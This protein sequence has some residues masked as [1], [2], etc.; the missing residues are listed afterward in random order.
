V[1]DKGRP[2]APLESP[3]EGSTE[4]VPQSSDN[5]TTA[6]D[7]AY[8]EW[9]VQREADSIVLLELL[10]IEALRLLSTEQLHAIKWIGLLDE[11]W[12]RL[13]LELEQRGEVA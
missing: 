9:A 12:S 4:S 3:A 6:K 1:T 10:A 11:G 5:Q 8:A 13:Y 7:L 2:E